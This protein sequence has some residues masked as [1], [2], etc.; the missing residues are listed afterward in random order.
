MK[1]LLTNLSIKYNI[2]T[3]CMSS[4]K[5]RVSPN[6]NKV[7]T[8]EYKIQKWSHYP[9]SRCI[10]VL[11]FYISS[12]YMQIYIMSD[13]QMGVSESFPN[14]TPIRFCFVRLK[15]SRSVN[16]K[17]GRGQT[18]SIARKLGFLIQVTNDFIWHKVLGAVQDQL[19]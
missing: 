19:L 10:Q 8:F 6:P 3:H 18:Q 16:K 13:A 2:P 14:K 7:I 12:G 5:D 4:I 1:T 17:V 15:W 9:I 11:L